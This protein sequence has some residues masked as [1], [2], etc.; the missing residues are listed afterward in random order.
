MSYKIDLLREFYN[1]IDTTKVK[2]ETGFRGLHYCS[3]L[4]RIANLDYL[5]FENKICKYR[6]SALSPESFNK[7]LEQH[8]AKMINLCAYFSPEQNSVF[9]F[10][11][12][13]ANTVDNDLKVYASYLFKNML[14]FGF[15]PLIIKSGHGYHFWCKINEPVSNIKLRAFMKYVRDKA[16][17]DII[18]KGINTD[19]LRCTCYPRLNTGDISIRLFGSTH[20][21]TG[22]FSN[23]VTRI[24]ATDTILDEFNSWRFFES[25]LLKCCIPTSVFL[26]TC[27]E[28]GI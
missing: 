26:N 6:I 4:N 23:I 12:D 22:C 11:L 14:L 2:I 16:T 8:I 15:Y 21:T 10:N 13:I 28:I 3:E 27:N 1:T 9:A 19:V 24:G 17:K 7:F 5:A 25:Y 18:N 20:V